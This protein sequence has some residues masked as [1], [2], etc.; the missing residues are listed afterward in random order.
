[1]LVS[2]HLGSAGFDVAY[3]QIETQ[4][5]HYFRFEMGDYPL[6]IWMDSSNS[7]WLE[8]S[9]VDSREQR[10]IIQLPPYVVER[11]ASG[12]TLPEAE[13]SSLPSGPENDSTA[14]L[15]IGRIKPPLAITVTQQGLVKRWNLE[16]EAPTATVELGSL[17]GAGQ[18]NVSGRY[19]VWRDPES[20]N[21]SLLDFETGDNRLIAPLNGTYTP[22]L[23]LSVNADVTIGVNVGLEPTVVGWDTMTGERLD[24]GEY[25]TCNRQPDMVRLSRDGTTL[26]IGCDTGLDVWRISGEG[27]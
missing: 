19:F 6:R 25:R 2:V 1:V 26:V 27:R 18:V 3:R 5:T 21:L 15:R 7:V 9:P 23:L 16:A 13:I 8:T 10:S 12:E 24:L 20:T 22:F 17:P 4:T 11:Y 14:F